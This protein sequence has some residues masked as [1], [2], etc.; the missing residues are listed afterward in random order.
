MHAN[1]PTTLEDAFEALKI[2]FD[3]SRLD[4]SDANVAIYKATNA[5]YKKLLKARDNTQIE[6]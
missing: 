2:A 4:M 1:M 3:N 5:H 6:K